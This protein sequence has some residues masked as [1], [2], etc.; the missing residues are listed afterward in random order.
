MPQKCGAH[1]SFGSPTNIVDLRRRVLDNSRPPRALPI[2]SWAL[3]A[4]HRAST[5]RSRSRPPRALPTGRGRGG[6]R[7]ACAQQRARSPRALPIRSCAVSAQHRASTLRV[8]SRPP[9]AFLLSVLYVSASFSSLLS[10]TFSRGAFGPP[11]HPHV[12]F[13]YLRCCHTFCSNIFAFWSAPRSLNVP[14]T[15]RINSTVLRAAEL[16]SALLRA[17]VL[18]LTQRDGQNGWAE[19]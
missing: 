1:V 13:L 3:S 17:P 11:P 4:Q 15:S 12:F 16:P 2:R 8:C 10:R 7:T 18:S 14:I 19:S 6:S 9:L 5:L